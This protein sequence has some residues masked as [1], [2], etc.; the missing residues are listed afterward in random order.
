[1][2]EEN[3]TDSYFSFLVVGSE[4]VSDR[5]QTRDQEASAD[6]LV[7][8]RRPSPETKDQL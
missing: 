1:M 2:E 8:V 4:G 3:A 7:P 5:Q 6:L